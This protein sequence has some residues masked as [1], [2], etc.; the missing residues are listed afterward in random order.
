MCIAYKQNSPQH[1]HLYYT[2]HIYPD[3]ICCCPGPSV[4]TLPTKRAARKVLLADDW[5]I[6]VSIPL[7]L[8]C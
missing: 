5:R 1:P 6:G 7:P 4:A 2:A 3:Q 8:A